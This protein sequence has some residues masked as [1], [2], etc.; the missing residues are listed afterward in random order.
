MK[1]QGRLHRGVWRM[2]GK[3]NVLFPSSVLQKRE[4]KVDLDL[5]M[6]TKSETNSFR[7]ISLCGK[8]LAVCRRWTERAMGGR[9]SFPEIPF[10][11]HN[12]SLSSIC[13][14]MG[15][16]VG[17]L[18]QQVLALSTRSKV[19]WPFW[20]D[21]SLQGS[22]GSPGE[23]V[24]KHT[25]ALFSARLFGSI[26]GGDSSNPAQTRDRTRTFLTR[27]RERGRPRI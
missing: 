6:R 1:M 12:R 14:R 16:H 3:S 9:S 27:N 26:L 20:R 10:N 13:K 24:W 18:R 21:N 22:L 5:R 19:S 11:L 4:E 2:S 17:R 8:D 15:Q 23:F 25:L 7:I